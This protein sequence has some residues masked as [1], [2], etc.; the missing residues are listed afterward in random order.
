MENRKEPGFYCPQHLDLNSSSFNWLAVKK[1]LVP[2]FQDP[3]EAWE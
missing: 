2:P 1:L 3:N